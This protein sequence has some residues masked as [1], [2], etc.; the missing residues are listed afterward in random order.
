[1]RSRPWRASNVRRQDGQLGPAN[2][3]TVV[4]LDEPD[5]AGAEHGICRRDEGLAQG[6]DRAEG[7][8]DFGD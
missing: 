1:M 6:F 7:A 4:A 8:F 2:L 3:T 5:E